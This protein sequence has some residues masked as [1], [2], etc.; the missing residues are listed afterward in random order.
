MTRGFV[1]SFFSW[2]V[3]GDVVKVLAVWQVLVPGSDEPFLSA[4]QNENQNI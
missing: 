4:N 2:L 1:A 3:V